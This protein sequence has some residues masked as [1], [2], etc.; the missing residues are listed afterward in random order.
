M[1]GLIEGLQHTHLFFLDRIQATMRLGLPFFE[2]KEPIIRA[3][4]ARV[5]TIKAD[6]DAVEASMHLPETLRHEASE[7]F[8]VG[9]FLHTA[10]IVP[11]ASRGNAAIPLDPRT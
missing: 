9:L 10:I 7:E 8:S 4:E 5:Y 11:P 6:V 2:R 1:H 3:V